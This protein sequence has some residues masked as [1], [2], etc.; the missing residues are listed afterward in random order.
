MDRRRFRSLWG[1]TLLGAAVIVALAIWLLLGRRLSHSPGESA[2]FAGLPSAPSVIVPSAVASQERTSEGVKGSEPPEPST[3]AAGLTWVASPRGVGSGRTTPVVTAP[4]TAA[5]AIIRNADVVRMTTQGVAESEILGALRQG[6]TELNLSAEALIKLK[7]DGVSERVIS[8]MIDTTEPAVAGLLRN[9][10]LVKMTR[11]GESD[12]AILEAIGRSKLAF[13]MSPESLIALRKQGVSNPV[14]AAAMAA[15]DA[16][17]GA[18]GPAS[19]Q[20]GSIRIHGPAGGEVFLN[21]VH[22]GSIEATGEL[23]L[24]GVPAGVHQLRVVAANQPESRDSVEVVGGRE[25]VVAALPPPSQP[26]TADTVSTPP[27]STSETSG[28]T[29]R[30]P[31]RVVHARL[32]SRRLRFV[33]IEGTRGGDPIPRASPFPAMR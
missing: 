18:P 9:E 12:A 2:L 26:S 5:A 24:G 31:R 29:F 32:P 4:V 33:T 30:F 23:I 13:D 16:R 25:T 10:D 17:P 22:R 15:G 20:A 19:S 3:T 11:S 28:R 14:I 7:K 6:P 1:L 21:N 8:A 27:R